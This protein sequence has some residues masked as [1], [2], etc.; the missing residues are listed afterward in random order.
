VELG[1]LAQKKA[2]HPDIVERFELY[3]GGVELANG[4]T[5]LTDEAEQRQRFVKEITA[6]AGLWERSV[7][8]PE[9]F[10]ED[11]KLLQSAAGIALGVDRLLMLALGL[12]DIRE[13]VTFS[14]S[15]F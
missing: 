12:G 7:A 10:L 8:I 6:I 2:A 4:F 14:P 5:E 1:S 11:L 15:D 13:V 3:L 9:R